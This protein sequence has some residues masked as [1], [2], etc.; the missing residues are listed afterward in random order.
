M[1]RKYLIL[2]NKKAVRLINGIKIKLFGFDPDRKKVT[3]EQA[4]IFSLTFTN[5]YLKE[6][7]EW[8]KKKILSRSK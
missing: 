1:T 2:N 5:E 3:D 7:K 6:G 4:I 8:N